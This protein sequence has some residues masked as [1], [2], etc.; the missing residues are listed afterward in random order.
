MRRRSLLV[1]S[2]DFPRWWEFEKCGRP[3]GPPPPP[4]PSVG[5]VRGFSTPLQSGFSVAGIAGLVQH[6]GAGRAQVLHGTALNCRVVE[7]AF[8]QICD[9][10]GT[11]THLTTRCIR[12]QQRSASTDGSRIR[13][14]RAIFLAWSTQATSSGT[15]CCGCRDM[16]SGTVWRLAQSAARTRIQGR[17][18]GIVHR[19]SPRSAQGSAGG[20]RYGS[21]SRGRW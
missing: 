6:A 16:R 7:V 14:G 10:C 20:P 9:F 12:A 3:F 18:A 19:S 11:M 17:D 13:A 21:Q 2:G 5:E 8:F 4:L 1:K 15:W